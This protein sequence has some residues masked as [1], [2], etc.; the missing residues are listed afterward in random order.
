MVNINFLV[1]ED[2]TIVWDT[3]EITLEAS[4]SIVVTAL[5]GQ[6]LDPYGLMKVK[7]H[8]CKNSCLNANYR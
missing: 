6:A 8:G 3:L 1:W 5:R 4:G 2:S 7:N